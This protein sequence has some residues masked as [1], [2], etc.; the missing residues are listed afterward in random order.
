MEVAAQRAREGALL[1]SA[2]GGRAQLHVSGLDGEVLSLGLFHREP[3]GAAPP[4]RWRRRTGGRAIA[5]GTGFRLVTLALPHRAALVAE[6]AVALRPEQALNRCVRGLLAALKRLAVDA[7]YPG[8]DAV[9]AAGRTLAVLGLGEVKDGSALFQAVLAWD[10]SFAR[11]PELL[12]RADPEGIVPMVLSGASSFT[13]IREL[14]GPA[15]TLDLA[16]FAALVAEGYREAF[17]TA[18]VSRPP[19]APRA[20]DDWADAPATGVEPPP[21]AGTAT[22][23]GR[24]GPVT[25]W[26]LGDDRDRVRDAGL[27]GDLMAPLD[28]PSDLGALLAGVPTSR[29]ALTAALAGWLDGRERYVLGVREAEL[30]DL[31]AAAA[32]K[33]R[34]GG[35]GG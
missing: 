18:I 5:A 4:R 28:L 35:D 7:L 17:G 20:S 14:R 30:I 12:D 31:L 26:V 9:T 1:A 23:R 2:R 13:S 10:Q 27:F 3:S 29:P 32:G 33:R 15:A 21:H 24:I 34:V 22:L 25:A 16:E 11:T 6:S 19:P 8:L